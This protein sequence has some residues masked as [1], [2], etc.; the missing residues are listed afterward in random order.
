MALGCYGHAKYSKID[1]LKVP[2][3]SA[4]LL[5][6][7]CFFGFV[8]YMGQFVGIYCLPFSLAVVLYFTQPISAAV[9]SYI[10]NGESLSPLQII[11]IFFAMFGVIVLT[12]PTFV[13]PFLSPED[14][15]GYNKSD[16]PN[17]NLGVF[18]ALFG[19]VMSGFAYLCMRKLGTTVHSVLNPLWFGTFSVASCF[20]VAA[21]LSDEIIVPLSFYDIGLL[22]S[23]GILGW[24]AQEGVSKA[25]QVEKAGRAAPLNYLQVVIAWIFDVTCF[26]GHMKWTDI[27]GTLSIVIFTFINSV[28]KGFCSKQ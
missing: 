8:S 24:I 18:F 11:S 27:I 25:I 17:F 6:G 15:I 2:Q 28:S 9:V 16:Y 5:F 19:S 21:A 13:F 7:R 4:T 3:E 14:A 20:V 22:L 26:G 12:N 23:M 1:V 10:F